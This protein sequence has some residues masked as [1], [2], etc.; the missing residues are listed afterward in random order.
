MGAIAYLPV[1]I[2]ASPPM[3]MVPLEIRDLAECIQL[4][5]RSDPFSWPDDIWRRSLRDDH[6]LGLVVGGELLAVAAFS[7]VLDELSLLN[8]V[9]DRS[10]RRQGLGRQLLVEGVEWMQQFG[11][12]RCVLEVRVSNSS[13]IALYRALG[14]AEDGIR[15][16]YYPL[17]GG[18]ENALLMSADLPLA[19]D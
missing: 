4:S 15:K 16:N 18:R 1:R 11:A 3:K 6:C 14:F 12:L 10:A 7:L 19:V 2:I 8:V 9:V 17:E 5:Q 13:A